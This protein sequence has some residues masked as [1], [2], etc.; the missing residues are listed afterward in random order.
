MLPFIALSLLAGGLTA[1]LLF[2]LLHFAPVLLRPGCNRGEHIAEV[3]LTCQGGRG[4][5]L[6]RQRFDTLAMARLY[7]RLYAAV[8]HLHLPTHYT[9]LDG[10]GRKVL[11]R[12]DYAIRLGVR[13][14]TV[15][16]YGAGFEPV[17]SSV[18]PGA[19]GFAGEAAHRHPV[20][21][22]EAAGNEAYPLGIA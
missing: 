12:H 18:L 22:K 9:V 13:Q 2:A 10:Q 6:Y 7:A 3:W 17:W 1:A 16:E 4:S 14:T 15:G 8:L 19:P 5:T 20:H 11:A 21:H